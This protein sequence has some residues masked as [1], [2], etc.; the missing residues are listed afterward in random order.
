[1]GVS[2]T[3]NCLDY[4]KCSKGKL[5]D[6]K[7]ITAN[8]IYRDNSVYKECSTFQIPPKTCTK[9]KIDEISY[10]ETNSTTKKVK[11]NNDRFFWSKVYKSPTTKRQV[12]IKTPIIKDNSLV[13][14][15]FNLLFPQSEC[16]NLS[17]NNEV[18]CVTTQTI[19]TSVTSFI[20][21]INK[22]ANRWC[23]FSFPKLSCPCCTGGS[24][25]LE[26]VPYCYESAAD[27]YESIN[28]KAD[29]KTLLPSL[30]LDPSLLSILRLHKNLKSKKTPR[31]YAKIVKIVL[32]NTYKNAV[33]ILEALKA[34]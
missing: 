30:E 8:A 19:G 7:V 24:D 20:R 14:A 33:S 12:E 28:L 6:I 27:S 11:T 2:C 18:P 32:Q 22:D 5:E 29:S 16:D 34:I 23:I 15:D 31:I 13:A 25:C 10:K 1:M 21:P 9:S 3:E 26:P 4:T 17:M